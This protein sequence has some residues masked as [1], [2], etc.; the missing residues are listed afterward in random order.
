MSSS[1]HAYNHSY[2]YSVFDLAREQPVFAEFPNRLHVGERAPDF[3][4]ENLA[5][6]QTVRL[7]DLWASGVA[8]LEFGSFT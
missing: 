1:D 7:R 6:G 4:F 5:D 8:I 2:N 3:P